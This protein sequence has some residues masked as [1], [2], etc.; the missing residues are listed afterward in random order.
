MEGYGL[1][2]AGPVTHSNPL[3][4]LRKVG[5]IGVPLPNTEAKIVDLVTGDS[6]PC[7]QI[8][9]MVVKGTAGDARLLGR[10]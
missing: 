8:G 10:A 9:E 7:G 4:G 3:Y 2:E 6:L 1:T 5:S